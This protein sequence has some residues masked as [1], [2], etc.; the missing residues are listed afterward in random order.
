MPLTCVKF[1]KTKKNKQTKKKNKK[2][3]AWFPRELPVVLFSS[4]W[5]DQPLCLN[6][7]LIQRPEQVSLPVGAVTLI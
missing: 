5:S 1:K 6:H 3:P 4:P 7:V 2:H